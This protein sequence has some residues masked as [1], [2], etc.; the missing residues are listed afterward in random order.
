MFAVASC[1]SRLRSYHISS[2]T[3][4]HAVD[5]AKILL[6]DA[7]SFSHGRRVSP[8]TV[9]V[10]HEYHDFDRCNNTSEQGRGRY[11]SLRSLAET[12]R[13]LPLSV[14]EFS[15]SVSHMGQLGSSYSVKATAYANNQR[16]C[17]LLYVSAVY[18]KR[19]VDNISSSYGYRG[20]ST[21]VAAVQICRLDNKDR[22]YKITSSHT[23]ALTDR[24][25][26][27]EKAPC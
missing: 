17:G 14:E 20:V 25:I 11:M 8:R 23:R 21:Y 9:G 13:F 24:Y 19:T 15:L 22:E 6:C 16:A 4:Y 10:N 18:A 5:C 27:V 1:F 7:L 2:T 26:F 12:L 3:S